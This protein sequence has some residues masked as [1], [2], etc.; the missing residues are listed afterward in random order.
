MNRKLHL[1]LLTLLL[2]AV[3]LGTAGYKAF[4]LHLPL[5]PNATSLLW[6][7]EASISFTTNNQPAKVSVFVPKSSKAL[8]VVDESF[9][10]S[11][12]GLTT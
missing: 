2:I 12:C 6:E 10:S 8:A 9:I 7:I 3:G 4:V 5:V 11:G 1:V